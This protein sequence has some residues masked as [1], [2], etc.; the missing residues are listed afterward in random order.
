M[1]PLKKVLDAALKRITPGEAERR[2][3]ESALDAVK[4]A[5]EEV[6]YPL[7]LSYTIAGSFIRDTWLPDKKEFDVFILFPATENRDKL[8]KRGLE[9]GKRIMKKLGG[10]YV[11]AY[12]EHPYVRGSLHGF[13][14]DIVPAFAVKSVKEMKSSVDRTPFHNKWLEGNLAA[15]LTPQVRL[16]KRF[17]KGIGVYGADAKTMG[18]SGY[19]CELLIV[20]YRSFEAFLRN[21]S[22]WE[23][24][25]E[26]IDP[27]G[28]HRGEKPWRF[29]SEP[30]VVVDPVDPNRNVAAALSPANF[31]KIVVRSREFLKKPSL[32]YFFPA[33]RKINITRLRK[34]MDRR[35][36]RLIGVKFRPPDVIDDVLW[37]Q[38]R[39]TS[40][41]IKDVL[42][43]SGFSV[44]NHGVFSD[45]NTALLLFEM[46]IWALPAI[47]KLSG[48]HI[49][50]KTN[51]ENFVKKYSATSRIWVEN[52]IVVAENM[53]PFRTAE[54]LIRDCLKGTAKT[55]K[56]RGIAS[57]LAIR[58]SGKH[59]LL[60]GK[61][62][63]SMASEN[64]ELG[65]FLKDFLTYSLF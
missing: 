24:G 28:H 25:K 19:L 23:A 37:P 13:H 22:E 4:K 39:K 48:P 49:F 57:H 46:Q 12:A 16:L 34:A 5:T 11:I 55:L 40:N 14:I 52:D 59:S 51:I 27:A 32:T 21:A 62:L 58:M 3:I 8:E 38:L 44:L 31:M 9:I 64:P 42:E 18:L 60:D 26:F 20:N 45:R 7:N 47:R 33:R 10:G 61:E 36:T 65:R 35:E 1:P 6:I 30:L 43:S 63:L 2:R 54:T 17:A 41:R 53:R 15:R 56:S 29:R 50:S